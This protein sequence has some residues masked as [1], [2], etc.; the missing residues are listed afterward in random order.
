MTSLQQS[1]S[2]PFG[3]LWREPLTLGE[4]AF[5]AAALFLGGVAYCQLY[6]LVAYQQMHGAV[7]PLVLSMKRSAF[8]TVPALAA[9]EL[10][11]RSLAESSLTKRLV[12]VGLAVALITALTI[13]VMILLGGLIHASAMP[14]RLMIADRLPGMTVTLLAIAWAERQ[15]RQ[16]SSARPPPTNKEVAVIIPPRERID[17]VKAAGN[18]VEL[19]VGE[20]KIVQRMTL[21]QASNILGNDLFVQ[22]HRSVLVNRSRI[23]AYRE[24]GRSRLLRL[25]DG[26]VLKIGNAYRAE[27][28]DE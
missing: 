26:T 24:T 2:E 15:M 22:I 13:A 1:V 18:Y 25:S 10:S 12:L 23:D 27:I 4:G 19:H 5:V 3:K 11:K 14:V 20:R 8:E 16:S 6:C 21:Q 28:F 7:M 17:W 9:F